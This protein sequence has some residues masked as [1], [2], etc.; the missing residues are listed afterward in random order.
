MILIDNV[1]RF[2]V[3][4]DGTVVR[5]SQR[6]EG[7]YTDPNYIIVFAR[8]TD[9]ALQAARS[10]TEYQ[11]LCSDARFNRTMR[12]VL[13]ALIGFLLGS[14]LFGCGGGNMEDDAAVDQHVPTPSN[15]CRSDR[16]VCK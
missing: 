16:E 7:D 13:L 9:A 2:R 12:Y 5:A 3:Y 15:P 10:N 14:V 6:L 1:M 4:V 11:L 8:D